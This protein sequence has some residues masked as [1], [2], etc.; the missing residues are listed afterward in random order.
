M[1]TSREMLSPFINHLSDNCLLPT[2]DQNALRCCCSCS[3]KYFLYFLI[4]QSDLLFFCCKLFHQCVSSKTFRLIQIFKNKMWLSLHRPISLMNVIFSR[5]LLVPSFIKTHQLPSLPEDWSLFV[6]SPYKNYLLKLFENITGLQFVLNHS[7]IW[8]LNHQIF[9]LILS[10]QYCLSHENVKIKSYS[11]S[12][13]HAHMHTC[14][15]AHAH[16]HT[17][18]HL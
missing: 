14:T 3:L 17:H 10:G 6:D 18:T 9:P 7:L 12:W 1:D 2:P 4:I 13:A 16:T 5:C 8:T 11:I 15:H